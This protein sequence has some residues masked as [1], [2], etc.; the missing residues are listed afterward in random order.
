MHSIQHHPAVQVPG[1][2]DEALGLLGEIES[3]LA[4]LQSAQAGG[5]GQLEQI[6]RRWQELLQ[7]EARIAEAFGRLEQQERWFAAQVAELE[8]RN[9]DLSAREASIGFERLELDRRRSVEDL[10]SSR[11]HADR[12]IALLESRLEE[13]RREAASRRADLEA[14][15]AA[16]EQERRRLQEEVRRLQRTLSERPDPVVREE[17]EAAVERA[18]SLE[19]RLADRERTAAAAERTLSRRIA[20]LE[21]S[22]ADAKKGL[23]DANDR[24]GRSAETTAR[25]EALAKQVTSLESKLREAEKTAASQ[26]REVERLGTELEQA[27]EASAARRASDAA[28]ERHLAKARSLEE[29]AAG[30]RS[31]LD[32]SESECASLRGELEKS[33]ESASQ[34]RRR[35]ATLQR[36][37]DHQAADDGGAKRAEAELAALRGRFDTASKRVSELEIALGEAE[38]ARRDAEEELGRLRSQPAPASAADREIGADRLETLESGLEK[39]KAALQERDARIETLAADLRAARESTRE[40]NDAESARL[41]H[42]ARQ[43]GRVATMLRSRRDRLKRVRD[44]LRDR[45]RRSRDAGAG[46]APPRPTGQA[47]LHE[48]RQVQQKREELRQVQKFLADSEVRMVR[49]WATRS[50]ASLAM[51]GTLFVAGLCAAAW[52]A[53]DHLW[54]APG[55][56]SVDLIARGGKGQPLDPRLADGWKAWHAAILADPIFAEDVAKRLEARGV[57]PG[58]ATTVAAM[59]QRDLKIDSDGPGRLRLVLSGEDRRLLPPVLDTVATTLAAESASQAPRR[60]DRTPAIVI[61]E[62]SRDGRIAYSLLDPRPLD[63]E[64]VMHAGVLAGGGLAVTVAI[65]VPAM[66]LLRRVRRIVPEEETVSP[67]N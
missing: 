54:P 53:S 51:I 42:K 11:Q 49:R 35:I 57:A 3:Q 55:T 1:S 14:R 21:R 50:A 45:V 29:E 65:A 64:R 8:R 4:R 23:A 22:L 43:L 7:R 40:T 27:R 9:G 58:D 47:A 66:F 32:R 34:H 17:H 28:A 19:T 12:Q 63:R 18:R 24:A 38:S 30:L 46:T 48:L 37:L 44:V 15:A 2:T 13:V 59:L 62:R 6:D 41:Q 31:R 60:P 67:A 25:A 20:G 39:A 33:R 61:G 5:A 10:A 26:A 36:Q 52:V 56:A 16:I